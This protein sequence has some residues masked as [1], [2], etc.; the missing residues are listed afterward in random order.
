MTESSL[1]RRDPGES[2]RRKIRG[3][4]VGSAVDEAPVWPTRDPDEQRRAAAAAEQLDRARGS[5][6]QTDRVRIVERALVDRVLFGA[7]I[8]R[9]APGVRG[10][11]VLD[12]G[13][14]TP[15]RMWIALT[16]V[17]GACPEPDD[18]GTMELLGRVAARLHTPVVSVPAVSGAC[19]YRRPVQPVPEG[20]SAAH[21]AARRLDEALTE[22][23]PAAEAH[24]A[25]TEFVHGMLTSRTVLIADDD[26]R[27][28]VDTFEFAGLGCSAEDLGSLLLHETVLADGGRRSFLAAYA[29]ERSQAAGDTLPSMQHVVFHLAACARCFFPWV[30]RADREVAGDLAAATPWLLSVLAGDEA[31]W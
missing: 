28:G 5:L 16:H 24:C 23:A 27:P 7:E 20:T 31:L 10:P 22:I 1:P 17:A 4:L 30:I 21:V 26:A 19:A 2:R 14:F 6:G 15:E 8:A 12:W 13:D 11:N 9:Q 25:Q 29:A 3:E 18:E